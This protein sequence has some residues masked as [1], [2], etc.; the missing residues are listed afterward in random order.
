MS[1]RRTNPPAL[2]RS[3]NALLRKSSRSCARICSMF[4][5]GSV[6]G[7]LGQYTQYSWYIAAVCVPAEAKR[8]P[9]PAEAAG[10]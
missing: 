9:A 7:G 3:R 1:L 10:G 5:E 2:G 8:P 6:S 4:H